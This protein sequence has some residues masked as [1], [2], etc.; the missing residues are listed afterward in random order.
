MLNAA[1]R[2]RPVTK[3]RP[4]NHVRTIDGIDLFCR[5]WGQGRPLLFL[6]GWCLNS[7]MWGYQM[8]P[9]A[10]D[11]FRCIAYDRR[12]HG[13]SGDAGGGY[14]F[15][16]LADDLA[17]VIE[18]LDLDEVTVVA[19]SFAS[20]E[21]VR[22][23]TRHGGSRVA[24]VIMLAP[25]AIPFLAK[26]AD[27]PAGI[28]IGMLNARTAELAEDFPG[29]AERNAAPYFAGQGSRGIIDATL[30]MMNMASH[31]AM[32]AL[33]DIQGATDFRPELVR[34][35]TRTLFIHGDRDA[36]IPLEITSRPACDL[37]KG[38]QLVVYEGGPHGLYVTHKDRL[39]RDI[40]AFA[41]SVA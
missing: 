31:Q 3:V 29:W 20:G 40:A 4:N 2:A 36:S 16:T 19:H 22:Y 35:D 8:E 18:A 1:A 24:G 25:A 26:T 39:N 38:A 15:D 7:L 37:V 32:L 5:D 41:R 23:L 14:D 11:G 12:G 28:D 21:I 34:L 13:R 10:R 9:L 17:A 33:T 30:G 27:N 6:S